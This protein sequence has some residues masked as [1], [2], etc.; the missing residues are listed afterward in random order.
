MMA[1]HDIHHRS[2][3]DTYAGLN[4]WDVPQIYNRSAEAIGSLQERERRRH[5]L[6][7]PGHAL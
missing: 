2:Q 3:M 4:G 5:G 7:D 1:E 6:G